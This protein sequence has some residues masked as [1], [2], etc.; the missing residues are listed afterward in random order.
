MGINF[1]KRCLR[2]LQ[3]CYKFNTPIVDPE[4]LRIQIEL[5]FK[6]VQ[7]YSCIKIIFKSYP[8]EQALA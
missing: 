3:L 4:N 5:I 8:S 1:I 6:R 2:Q 7:N